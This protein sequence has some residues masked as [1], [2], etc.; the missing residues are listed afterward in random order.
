VDR[1]QLHA[2]ADSRICIVDDDSAVCESLAGLIRSFGVAVESFTSADSFL[3]R[4][5]LERTGCLILDM[6]MPGMSGPDLQREL[7]VRGH[8]VPIVFITAY[9]DEE[10]RRRVLAEGAVDCL[11]KPFSG[12]ALLTA[13]RAALARSRPVETPPSGGGVS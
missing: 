7:A 5:A 9:G 8:H 4:P 1:A 13:I 10:A 6:Q 11:F 3:K 12:E 2:D